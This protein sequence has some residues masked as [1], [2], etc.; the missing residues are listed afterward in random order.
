MTVLNYLLAGAFSENVGV[1]AELKQVILK[2]V[3]ILMNNYDP[4]Q[5]ATV[6]TIFLVMGGLILDQI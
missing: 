3:K 5:L 6:F 2:V 1:F 4:V